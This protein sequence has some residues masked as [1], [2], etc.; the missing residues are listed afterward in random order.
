[1]YLR[2]PPASD[3]FQLMSLKL[4][5]QLLHPEEPWAHGLLSISWPGFLLKV[6]YWEESRIAEMDL[7]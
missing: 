5:G 4:S 6:E 7:D 3:A 2:F 1:M